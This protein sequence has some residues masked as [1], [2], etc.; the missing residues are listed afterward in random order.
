MKTSVILFI[1]GVV[2]I[3]LGALAKILHWEAPIGGNILIALGFMAE[4]TAL[5]LLLV[6]SRRSR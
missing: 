1:T 4:I 5:C 3:I 6:R 2:L